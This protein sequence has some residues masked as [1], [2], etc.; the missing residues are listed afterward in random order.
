MNGN[1]RRLRTWSNNRLRVRWA[2]INFHTGS[3][4]RRVL[5]VFL[6]PVPLQ[7][8]LNLLCSFW[9]TISNLQS[10]KRFYFCHYRRGHHI[11]LPCAKWLKSS[12]LRFC[13]I[14]SR[15]IPKF[16]GDLLHYVA[17]IRSKNTVAVHT[18]ASLVCWQINWPF[19]YDILVQARLLFQRLQL[20]WCNPSLSRN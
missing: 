3:M 13:T 15:S 1:I 9:R 2:N 6:S 7:W 14:D 16:S 20:S 11:V 18:L 5:L 17:I 19:Q 10:Y 4:R 8:I 12:L